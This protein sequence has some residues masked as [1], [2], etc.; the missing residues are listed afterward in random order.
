MRL[1]KIQEIRLS[2]HLT[3]HPIARATKQVRQTAQ[4]KQLM[5][6]HKIV[7]PQKALTRVQRMYLVRQVEKQGLLRQIALRGITS[8]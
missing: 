8:R 1:S 7:Q 5:R 3:P 6:Q 4:S 2:R